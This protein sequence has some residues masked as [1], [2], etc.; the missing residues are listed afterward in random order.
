MSTSNGIL[1]FVEILTQDLR[2]VVIFKGHVQIKGFKSP[3]QNGH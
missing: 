1:G 3:K 2:T